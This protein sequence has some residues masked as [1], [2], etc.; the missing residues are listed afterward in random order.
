MEERPKTLEL[1]HLEDV[2]TNRCLL[3]TY[4]MQGLAGVVTT[5][6]ARWRDRNEAGQ[7]LQF[8]ELYFFLTCS[9]RWQIINGTNIS[10]E[11]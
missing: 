8:S 5:E 6:E 9:H 2:K 3:L 4:S 7:V 1:R 10:K 11:I